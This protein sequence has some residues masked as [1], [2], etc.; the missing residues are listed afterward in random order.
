MNSISLIGRFTADPELKT[1]QSGTSVT[2]F[3]IAVNRSYVKQ[4]EER[5]A[6]F[7]DCVAWRGT[8]EFIT[9]YFRKGQQIAITGSLETRMFEDRE[10]KKRKAYEVIVDNV[11]FCG[12]RPAATVDGIEQPNTDFAN[13]EDDEDLPF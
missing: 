9:K 10:G 11:Y 3:T 2:S 13:I 7:I 6:D 8:A 5:K 1:T 4:G 12:D